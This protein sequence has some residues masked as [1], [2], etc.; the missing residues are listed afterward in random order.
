MLTFPTHLFNPDTITLKPAGSVISGGESLSGETDVIRTDGG[1]YWMI[2]MSGIDLI[3]DA[4]LKAWQ[5]W[6]DHLD[7]GATKVLVPVPELRQAPRPA[8]PLRPSQLLATSD[9][10][11]FP[12]AL[13]FATP[14]ITAS[15]VGAGA[16]R[17]TEITIDVTGGARLMGGER[18]AI[19]NATSGRRVHRVRRVL[20]RGGTDGQQATVS[21]RPPLREA[22]T[23]GQAVDFDW[24]SVVATLMPDSNISPV[25]ERGRYARVDISFREAF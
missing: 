17:A 9:D 2:I 11:Y 24:P 3:N 16:L 5:A 23:N 18:F 1:G 25:I 21:I 19:D 15:I 10:P 4:Q 13:A 8:L 7:G 22:V 12:E 20:S 6:E 14:W